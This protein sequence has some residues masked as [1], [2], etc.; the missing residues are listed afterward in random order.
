MLTFKVEQP[1][2]VGV[3]SAEGELTIQH[4][5]EMRTAL[6]NAL[7]SVG[8]VRLNFEKVTEI[9]LSCL[10]LLCSAHLTSARTHKQL[11]LAGCSGPFKQAVRDFVYPHA[12]NCV[13]EC[14]KSCLMVEENLNTN[15]VF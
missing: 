13:P 2:V 3:L 8:H 9:D 12:K 1:G 14:E 5:S 11:T 4:A 15:L 10:Q 6:L 7:E